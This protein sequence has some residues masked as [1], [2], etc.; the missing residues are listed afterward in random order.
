MQFKENNKAI[1]LQIADTI[2]D[3]VLDGTFPP[4]NRIPSVREYATQVEV[5]ANTVMRA[6]DHLASLG[7]IYNKRGIGYFIC[8]DAVKKVHS[9]R[10][11]ELLGGDMPQLFHRLQLLGIT[12][13]ELAAFYSD[14]CS[15]NT[16]LEK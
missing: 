7:I 14:Y 13:G 8:L 16:T 2:C 5:N 6:Y 12:P 1:Y 4:E 9:M 3:R 11:E 10:R 15:T